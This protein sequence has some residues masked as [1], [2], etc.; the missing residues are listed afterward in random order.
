MGFQ[1][2]NYCIFESMNTSSKRLVSI[3][4]Y[5]IIIA[6]T[7]EITPFI[8]SPFIHGHSFSRSVIQ[9]E[10]DQSNVLNETSEEENT[11]S[12]SEYL[13]DH[14]L[15]PYLGFVSI[16]HD[17]YNEFCLPGINP[18]IK[19]SP[20]QL[21]V[22][23]MGGSVAKD[24]YTYSGDRLKEKLEVSEKYRDKN[25]N[26][27]VFALG[28]FKQ[29]QQLLALNYFMA[30]GAEYDVVINLDGFN[31]IV[32]PYSDNLPFHVYPSYPRHW[33]IYAR[34]KLDTKVILLMGKQA[35]EKEKQQ[36]CK[37]SLSQ[38]I[39]RYSNFRL[40][41]WQISNNQKRNA[42]AALE[43]EVRHV[44]ENSE[45]NYQATGIYT[46]I[47]DT[48]TFFRDQAEFWRRSS[49]QI[50][51]ISKSA[52]FEYYHFLQ[53]NQYVAGSK[54]LTKEEM[55]IAYEQ[56]PF[57][58][59]D[60][61]QKGYPMLIEEGTKLVSKNINFVDL[62]MLFKNDNRTIYNDKC[63]HYNQLGYDLIADRIAITIISKNN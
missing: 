27:V 56:E 20:E 61:A 11:A 36:Q 3:L 12:Q 62:T 32:L 48:T 46:D 13:G 19:K 63:C 55:Q 10:L 14:V 6:V 47:K 23:I 43:A 29:P 45:S 22:V 50:S 4:V 60:A 18:I 52:G 39:A 53:P 8:L 17:T 1:N 31:E 9:N 41:L 34:K 58:Y 33:N 40:F 5:L 54:K 21:N 26:L 42:I 15:H 59:K 37:I 16:P 7:L 28:G 25:V 30:L 51:H 35:I 57:S 49:E 44:M 24:L 2:C 38:S